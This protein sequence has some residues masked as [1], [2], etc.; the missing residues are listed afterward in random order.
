MK[1]RNVPVPKWNG[2]S[3]F[4][5]DVSPVFNKIK[6]PF[7]YDPTAEL[8]FHLISGGYETRNEQLDF[9]ECGKRRTQKEKKE[10]SFDPLDGGKAFLKQLLTWAREEGLK[11]LIHALELVLEGNVESILKKDI[12][13]QE[14][15]ARGLKQKCSSAM[16]EHLDMFC[17]PSHILTPA[18][19]GVVPLSVPVKPS[20]DAAPTDEPTPEWEPTPE[21]VVDLVSWCKL[22][23]VL[24]KNGAW[25]AIF[26]SREGA[27]FCIDPESVH[28]ARMSTVV[29]CL[30]K[31]RLHWTADLKHWFY[32]IPIHERL[33]NLF[34]C[35]SSARDS[36]IYKMCVVPQGWSWSPRI[37]QCIG[38]GI[39]LYKEKD[40]KSLFDM[41][42]VSKEQP[43]QS[44]KLYKNG[45]ET[46]EVFLWIDNI[47]L[48]RK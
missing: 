20:D 46:G 22:F 21:L 34:H 38:W 9:K 6:E 14:V 33:Q 48:C 11:W 19:E 32:Q 26:D 42:K 28:F 18:G 37:A 10:I 13:E 3:L 17:E 15:R 27:K 8:G 23:P 41:S 1:R 29:M 35:Q 43:P 39:L 25:R 40:A 24:K 47:S 30:A 4:P 12:T 16:K 44:L 36:P 45:K 31:Y 2:P 7:L 5:M